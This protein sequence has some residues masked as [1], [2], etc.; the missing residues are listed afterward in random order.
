MLDFTGERIVPQS[1]KCEPNFASRMMHEHLVRYLFAGQLVAGKTV[2]DVGCGVGY[3]AQKLGLM[4]A[5]SVTA[6]DISPDAVAHAA[7]FYAHP[8]V[9]YH[10]GDAEDF[11]FDTR[12]D[13]VTCFE[14]IE[15]VQHPDRVLQCI[16]RHLKPDGILI[17]STPRF[18]G[19]KRTH[20]HV[21]E[22]TLDE[23]M[24]LM[25]NV[26]PN[27][28]IYFENNHFSSMVTRSPAQG[29]DRIEYL[30]DQFTPEQ[31]DVFISVSCGPRA[32]QPDMKPGVI[33]DDDRYV[34]M[35]E[36]DVAILHK[37]EDDVRAMLALEREQAR[38]A[39]DFK[40][41]E[42]ARLI[43]EYDALFQ[44][45][46]AERARAAET[47]DARATLAFELQQAQDANAYK[48]AEI[49]R[50]VGEYNALFAR[51]E[52]ERAQFVA[53]GQPRVTLERELAQA[54]EAC[55]VKD[56]EIARLIGEYNALFARA[57]AERARFAKEQADIDRLTRE[58][59]ALRSELALNEDLLRELEMTLA[60]QKQKQESLHNSIESLLVRLADADARRLEAYEFARA[61][62][63]QSQA[64][65]RELEILKRDLIEALDFP[66]TVSA[67][68]T[69]DPRHRDIV[70]AMERLFVGTEAT[71]AAAR[72]PLVVRVAELAAANRRCAEEIERFRNEVQEQ[73]ARA[74][75]AEAFAADWHDQ[76]LKL[77]Q[78][79]TWRA[80]KPLRALGRLF[81]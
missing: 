66:E 20:F 22:F 1:D 55:D 28:A 71:H 58:G 68:P 25:T 34:Q 53:E 9:T 64:L 41:A 39:S 78:S 14:M 42:I 35:L 73:R 13:V 21:R 18:L 81:R 16:E 65:R 75:R 19:E 44:R 46:E 17:A 27:T 52:A 77:R 10:V 33:F 37:A 56:A 32:Q 51:V 7:E 80:G 62:G 4:G 72:N 38:E 43:G 2:L 47:E 30:K 76:I 70:E 49:A 61:A 3:G 40:D 69:T 60:V 79:A 63:D 12:F 59:E 15:H 48:D 8:A 24:A 31:A 67:P 26:F 11:A 36:S 50:L 6:F 23:Y 45:A 29:I 54:R 57:E 74:D 5:T